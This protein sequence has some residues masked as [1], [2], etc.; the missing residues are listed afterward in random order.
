MDGLHRGQTGLIVKV[1]KHLVTLLADSTL[2]PIDVFAKDLKSAIEVATNLDAMSAYDVKDVVQISPTELGVVVKVEKGMLSILNQFGVVVKLTPSQIRSKR[3]SSVKAVTS[4]ISGKPIS[5]GDTVYVMEQGSDVKKPGTILHIYRTAVFVH[6]GQ[7]L[8]NNGILVARNTAL[9]LISGKQGNASTTAAAGQAMN[10]YLRPGMLGARAPPGQSMGGARG[11][12]PGPF[13]MNKT[14]C[15]KQGPHKGL[16]G[17]VKDTTETT[18]T[19]ELHSKNKKVSVP[20]S[21]LRYEDGQGTRQFR[22][23]E[24]AFSMGGPSSFGTPGMGMG[25]AMS[26]GSGGMRMEDRFLAYGNSAPSSVQSAGAMTPMH[27]AGGRTPA[28]DNASRTP[29]MGAPGGQT[30]AWYGREKAGS[31]RRVDVRTP[32][33]VLRPAGTFC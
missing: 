33:C 13:L 26:A 27:G 9:S 20:L 2:L 4:D 12:G 8:E 11:G 28:W 3:D 22:D 23:L 6:S 5:A 10:P 14:V 29:Y 32:V 30:P 25:P 1:N 19:V 7:V 21:I 16:V 17:I 31:R 24:D 15:I 18:A